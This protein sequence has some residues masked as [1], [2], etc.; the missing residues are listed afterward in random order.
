MIPKKSDKN[1]WAGAVTNI[2][3]L[4]E[5]VDEDDD[6]SQARNTINE[7]DNSDNNWLTRVSALVVS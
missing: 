6:Q 3:A 7:H 4:L 2:R 5:T 1:G